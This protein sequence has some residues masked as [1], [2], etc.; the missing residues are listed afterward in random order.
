MLIYSSFAFEPL[1]A[2]YKQRGFHSFWVFPTE[3]VVG[4]SSGKLKNTRFEIASTLVER[5]V[6]ISFALF[7]LDIIGCESA[8]ERYLINLSSV[9]ERVV[10]ILFC[11]LEVRIGQHRK[12]IFSWS[13]SSFV[14]KRVCKYFVLFLRRIGQSRKFN[15]L[16]ILLL[17]LFL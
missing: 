10:N 5:N 17:P 11:F 13:C 15:L 3:K 2:A 6:W 14:T 1:F 8:V 7:F 9:T 4:D 12:F 16:L